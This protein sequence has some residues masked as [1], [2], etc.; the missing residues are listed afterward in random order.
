MKPN[1]DQDADMAAFE[2][3][4]S[5]RHGY[6]PIRAG[7]DYEYSAGKRS[8]ECWQAAKADSR[9]LNEAMG[10]KLLALQDALE[11]VCDFAEVY[12]HLCGDEGVL[13]GKA[14]EAL[15]LAALYRQSREIQE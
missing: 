4:Y 1:P 3:W 5:T 14:H 10:K 2:K 6:D 12:L 7:D 13:G 9:A 15:T 11:Q 8:W